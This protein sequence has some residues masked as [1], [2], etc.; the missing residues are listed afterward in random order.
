MTQKSVVTQTAR[1]TEI[2]ALPDSSVINKS[3]V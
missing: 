1:Q 2:A 3:C